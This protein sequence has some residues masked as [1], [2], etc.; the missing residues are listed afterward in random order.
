MRRLLVVL[1]ISLMIPSYAWAQSGAASANG[2]YA[3]VAAGTNFA[4]DMTYCFNANVCSAPN[5]LELDTGPYIGVRVGK[6]FGNPFRAELELG[7]RRNEAEVPTLSGV[8]TGNTDMGDIN[9]FNIMLNGIADFPLSDGF[10]VYAGAG[11]GAVMVEAD[12]NS[13]FID[14]AVSRTEDDWSYGVQGILGAAW[15]IDSNVN[16][17]LDYRLLHSPDIEI[18]NICNGF[19]D[20]IDDDYTAHTVSIG[21]RFP[22]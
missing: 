8:G 17:I 6:R 13:S 9:A 18:R 21:I 1:A 22:L 10:S 14:C 20:H 16:L 7:Y 3:E 11:V 4:E 12:V 2:W 5:D 15:A 19:A